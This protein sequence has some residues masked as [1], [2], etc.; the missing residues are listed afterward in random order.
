MTLLSV[1][2]PRVVVESMMVHA[3]TTEREEVMGLLLG[4]IE[5]N[6][7]TVYAI[8][9]LQRQDKRKDR[10]EVSDHQLVE[11]SQVAEKINARVIGWYHSH[12]HITIQPSHV[13]VRTQFNYQSLDA[14]FFGLIVSV[15]SSD[16]D[17]KGSIRLI[18]FQT[19]KAD[20]E[21]NQRLKKQRQNEP[22]MMV[23]EDHSTGQSPPTN[24]SLI[25]V[26]IPIHIVDPQDLIS[27]NHCLQQ[28]AILYRLLAVEERDE[29]NKRVQFCT[30]PLARLNHAAAYQQALCRLLEYS[31]IPQLQLLA[32]KK[33]KNDIK[34]AQLLAEKE[35]LTKLKS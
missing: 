21:S 31:C 5:N 14:G 10:V 17:K 12:P 30:H 9:I 23:L 18:G 2:I 22:D 26:H 13:D 35:H 29:Y 8:Q 34:I 27:Y 7:A 1:I 32:E 16:K 25:D 3:M 28:L 15:F 11:A 24:G 4:K 20:D 6:S 33:R 19:V